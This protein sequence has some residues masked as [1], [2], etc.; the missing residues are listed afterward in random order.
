MWC[1]GRGLRVVA[2][3]N[4]VA[5]VLEWCLGLALVVRCVIV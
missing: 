2:L 4:L 1:D 3:C 5:A